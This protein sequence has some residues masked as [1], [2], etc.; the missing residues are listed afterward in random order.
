MGSREAETKACDDLVKDEQS[1]IFE[2]DFTQK[3]KKSRFGEHHPHIGRNGFNYDSC[4]GLSPL[5]ENLPDRFN[6]VIGDDNGVLGVVLRYACR[7]GD[8]PREEAGAGLHEESVGVA[9]VAT[10][11]LED[12]VAT[13]EPAGNADGTHDRLGPRTDHPGD[14]HRG[15]EFADEFGHLNL[16]SRGRAVGQPLIAGLLHRLQN[17]RMGMPQDARPPRADI[18]DVL[19]AVHIDDT[20]PISARDEPRDASDRRTGTDRTV[21]ATWH[22]PF[23]AIEQRLRIQLNHFATSTA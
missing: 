21:H 2:R 12:V 11:E 4:E 3:L 7:C 16:A 5:G 19:V 14:F 15:D 10:F 17:L 18:I 6:V 13:R 9:M 23:C 20:I 8:R 1:S 22:H